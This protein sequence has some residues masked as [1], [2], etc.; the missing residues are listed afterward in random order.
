MRIKAG[1]RVWLAVFECSGKTS[2]KRYDNSS[3]GLSEEPTLQWWWEQ[4]S[5]LSE[6]ENEEKRKAA[7]VPQASGKGKS[8]RRWDQRGKQGADCEVFVNQDKE[9]TQGNGW[10]NSDRRY[11]GSSGSFTIKGIM[12]GM[13]GSREVSSPRWREWADSYFILITRKESRS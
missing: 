11:S 10:V 8:A 6:L 4:C 5:L 12:W 9:L 1:D 3:W 2:L 13:W 7:S